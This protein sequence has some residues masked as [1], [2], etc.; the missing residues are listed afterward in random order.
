[1]NGRAESRRWARASPASN[2]ASAAS[3]KGSFRA[4]LRACLAGA[5][6]VARSTTRSGSRAK[7]RGR[8]ILVPARVVHRL[9]ESCPARC[10]AHRALRGR[11]DRSREG[12]PAA[13]AA[14]ARRRRR[15][16]R[17]PC[18]AAGVALVARRACRCRSPR[19]AGGARA[20]ARRDRLQSGRRR[21]GFDLAIEAAGST[22][23]V[24]AAA[25]GSCAA[26]ARCCYSDS[27]LRARRSLPGDLLVNNDLLSRQALATRRPPGRASSPCERRHVPAGWIVTHTYGLDA[28]ERAF[29]ELAEPTEAAARSCSRWRVAEI[30]LEELT[31]VYADGTLAVESSTSRSATAS[32][33]SSSARRVAERRAS[34]RMVAGLEEISGGRVRSETA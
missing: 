34:L 4:E 17:A 8:P 20:R 27:R 21:T 16:D 30:G 22:G 5:T 2:P 13:R 11:A 15:H 32:L 33:W 14:C 19:R 26:A 28:F 6:N 7:G 10:R 24:T 3:R 12:P 18:R 9:A 23:A 25:L 29:A 1:M 31:K